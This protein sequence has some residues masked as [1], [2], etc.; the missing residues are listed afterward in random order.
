MPLPA[1]IL[2]QPRIPPNAGNIIRLC[3]NTGADL[4]LVHPL[5]FSLDDRNVRRAGLDYHKL[6]R[7]FEQNSLKHCIT[8]VRPASVFGFTTRGEVRHDRVDYTAADALLFG[9]ETTGLPEA[10]LAG[11]SALT[12]VRIPMLPGSRSMNLANSVAVA[13]HE[14]WRQQGFAGGE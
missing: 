14:A 3:A 4:H 6:A 10:V 9:P 7:V 1:V 8:S 2:Y 11:M 13:V 5:G 12:R